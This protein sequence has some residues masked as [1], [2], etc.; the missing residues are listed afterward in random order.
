MMLLWV[1]FVV[2]IQYNTIIQLIFDIVF[3]PF[4]LKHAKLRSALS[5]L[6]GTDAIVMQ[7]TVCRELAQG[8]CVAAR[9]Q[10]SL[11]MIKLQ[12]HI[13]SDYAPGF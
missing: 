7:S 13:R 8:P 10:G 2:G 4:F 1:D 6:G 11:V 12:M 9:I 5:R 3:L